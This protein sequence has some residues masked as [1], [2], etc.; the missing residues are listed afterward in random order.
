M[1]DEEYRALVAAGPAVA[2][3]AKEDMLMMLDRLMVIPQLVFA[4]QNL[5]KVKYGEGGT[6]YHSNDIAREAIKQAGGDFH[7]YPTADLKNHL[8]RFT[9]CDN[10]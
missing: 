6:T 10:D 4:L 9:I 3:V 5:L 2:M 7:I 8:S 1:N